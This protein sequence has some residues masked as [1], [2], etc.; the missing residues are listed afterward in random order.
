[1]GA[2]HF[3]VT[4]RFDKLKEV[5]L[6]YAFLFKVRPTRHPCTRRHPREPLQVQAVVGAASSAHTLFTDSKHVW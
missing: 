1:M 5:A 2:G 3:S 4:G 6:D